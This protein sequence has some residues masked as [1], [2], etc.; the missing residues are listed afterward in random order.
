[1]IMYHNEFSNFQFVMLIIGFIM[2]LVPVIAL[3]KL[4][5]LKKRANFYLS[6]I[7]QGNEQLMIK[8]GTIP[9][10]NPNV[11]IIKTTNKTTKVTTL[12]TAKEW[13]TL[14]T[15]NFFKVDDYVE[16]F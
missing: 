2:W 9:D 4:V 3:F 14:D 11:D 7:L 8:N 1:M 6:R 10:Y 12:F 13:E 5:S 16:S 15:S